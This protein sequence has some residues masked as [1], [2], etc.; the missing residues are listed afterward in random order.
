[1]GS[2]QL[3]SAFALAHLGALASGFAALVGESGDDGCVVAA[4]CTGTT[5][6]GFVLAQPSA[7]CVAD[8]M[9]SAVSPSFACGRMAR[10]AQ[11]A[12]WRTPCSLPS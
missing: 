6:L 1:M 3:V 12:S 11:G 7:A 4:P 2:W 5:R 9:S 8:A 10:A